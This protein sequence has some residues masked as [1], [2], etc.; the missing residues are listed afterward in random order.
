[1]MI[2]RSRFLFL[3]ACL[4]LAPLQSGHATGLTAPVPLTRDVLYDF[5]DQPLGPI[6]LG[7]AE[8]GQPESIWSA[9]I[10][11][12]VHT[13]PGN[14]ALELTLP[15]P[16]AGLVRFRAPQAG[17]L[18]EGMVRVRFQVTP[19]SLDRYMILFCNPTSAC[20]QS[21]QWIVPGTILL[22][23][24]GR[25]TVRGGGL[26]IPQQ[27]NLADYEAGETLNFV[28]DFNLD[29]NVWSL[30]LN[31][32]IILT[33]RPFTQ[34]SLGAIHRIA[35]GHYNDG[36][37]ALSAGDPMLLDDLEI[38]V[39][40]PMMTVLAAD[41]NDKTADEPIGTGGARE[42][43]P[44]EL[45][46]N[47][48]TK[49]VSL[50]AGNQALQLRK[51]G[52][53]FTHT[54]ILW[55]FLD[56][57]GMSE[58]TMLAEFKFTPQLVMAQHFRLEASNDGM[59]E[60]LAWINVDAVGDI[61]LAF[62]GTTTRFYPLGSVS[63]GETKA[64]R[65]ACNLDE[66]HCS[67]A[68]NDVWVALGKSFG[69][70]TSTD[71]VIDRFVSGFDTFT[72]FGAQYEFNDLR[73]LAEY[74]PGIPVAMEFLAQ[75]EDRQCGMGQPL[76]LAITAADGG[77]AANGIEVR[78]I[79]DHPDITPGYMAGTWTETW[80]GI[81]EFPWVIA[82]RRGTDLR[83][84]AEID[85]DFYPLSV[86]SDPFDVLPGLPT[87]TNFEEA[88]GDGFAGQLFDPPVA[89]QVLDTC[90]ETS[91][92]GRE[93][94]LVILEG[95]DGATLTGNTGVTDAEGRIAFPDLVIEQPGSYRLAGSFDGSM[96]SG[97]TP[98]FTVS[99]AP[100]AAATFQVQPSTVVAT[101]SISPAVEIYVEDVVDHPVPDGTPVTLSLVDPGSAVL[102]GG[103]ASTVEGVAV[104]D[105]LQVS[106]PGSFQLRASVP[107]LPSDAEPVSDLFAVI[108]GPAANLVF[109]QQPSS[110]TAG[111]TI[112][113]SV[114]VRVTDANGFDLDDGEMVSLSLASAPAGAAL[115]GTL[116][117]P[118]AGGIATFNDLSLTVAGD[119]SLQAEVAVGPTATSLPFSIAPAA[120]HDLV[121]TAEPSDAPVNQPLTPVVSVNATDTFGNAVSDGLLISL[122]IAEG[123][124]SASLTGA[125][126][127][128]T[129]G[130]AEFPS[131][132]IDQP[133]TYQLQAQAEG[134]PVDG[135]PISLAF[136]ILAGAPAS[137]S[138]SQ[139]PTT[140]SAGSAISPAV[141][142]SVTD[143][144]GFAVADG[145]PVNLSLASGPAEAALVGVTEQSTV[146]GIATFPDLT[147]EMTGSYTLEAAIGAE[148]QVISS[149]FQVNSAA[150]HVLTFLTPPSDGTVNQPL[151]P[152]VMVE[153]RDEFDNLVTESTTVDLMLIEYPLHG[154]VSGNVADTINGVATFENLRFDRPG[155]WQ[156]RARA[157]GVSFANRPTS[158]LFE[159]F[160]GPPANLAFEQQPSTTAMGEIIAPAVSVR[161]TD[162]DG[163]D[164]A[165]GS[166]VELALASGPSGADLSGTLSQAT[167]DGL[168]VF[169]DLSLDLAGTYTLQASVSGTGL[170]MTSSS[171]NVLDTTPGSAA[172]LTEPST[173]TA[174]ES[175]TPPVSV[176]VLD[177]EGDAIADGTAVVLALVDPG[178]AT[179]TGAVATT[180]NGIATFDN[181]VISHPGSYQLRAEISGLDPAAHPLSAAFDILP[182]P[183]A[184]LV[185]EQQPNST[186]AGTAIS[187]TVAVSVTDASGFAVADGTPVNL[188][189]ASGPAEAALVGVT[190]RNTVDGV[191]T[192][193]DLT[194]EVTGSYTLEAAIG[195]ELQVISSAFQ[196]NS[197][198]PHVLTFLTPPSDGT[199]NQALTP[200]ITV[201]A[202]DE[203][204][205][206]VTGATAITL[207]PFESPADGAVSGNVADTVD[208]MATFDALSF[209]TPGSWRLRADADGVPAEHRPISEPFDILSGA[210]D[211]LAFEQQ[212]ST[213]VVD[214]VIAPAVS[215]RVTDADGFDVADGTEVEL[216]LASGRVGANLTGTLTRATSDGLAVFD[217]LSLDQA[218]AYTLQASIS[219]TELTATS[220]SFDVIDTGP[221]SASFFSEPSDT[222]AGQAMSP[223]VAVEVLDGEGGPVA[224]GSAVVLV[225][226]APGEAT[227]SGG[228]ATTSDGIAEFDSLVVNRPGSYQLRAEISGLDPAEQ[229][230][231]ATFEVVPGPAA[232]IV[233]EQQPTDT[234]AGQVITP[235]IQVRLVDEFGNTLPDGQAIT[236]SIASGPGAG[237]ISGTLNQTTTDGVAMFDDLAIN[238]AGS[239][240]SLQFSHGEIETVSE[241]FA[242]TS[243]R[244]FSDRF[245]AD[246]KP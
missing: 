61:W 122:V 159:I 135:Q 56:E 116:T 151:S 87:F 117:R 207:S 120:A 9:S 168:A 100:P 3:V 215:V 228:V 57:I 101:E 133:G 40:K 41:F 155:T 190:E 180:S 186:T 131:L 179:L 183:A 209:N 143:A 211:M 169:G 201:E 123:P 212:P 6:G 65:I 52:T 158:E 136:D 35:V 72:S 4:L 36:A 230:V 62:P 91:I 203:F 200:A 42:G 191:A 51:T 225:L 187:P 164:V 28:A 13:G 74:P 199:V 236:V 113:P 63:F 237:T 66:R 88:P 126:A 197:A 222:A 227:L 54:E 157:P 85:D 21:N 182:G 114:T 49:I 107:D 38:S 139:Q 233:V 134:V 77:P 196:V 173:T 14:R 205:N 33:D 47:L 23:P 81:A 170:T 79:P 162:A 97:A 238:Q 129:S 176:E 83:L 58:G 245:Q 109:E 226:V 213:T 89:V 106:Q 243:D 235:A 96:L 55:T 165:D 11:E 202:R 102:S 144:D 220:A 37:S 167:S 223:A 78:L 145:T 8:A 208:G 19:S 214:E 137:I 174:G 219:G 50:G 210:A 189:L 92:A 240:Y 70:T 153:A 84:I 125:T 90:G 146:D 239:E 206:L 22:G 216:A 119:Y 112:S 156:I 80:A 234:L 221:A 141:A 32:E 128:T 171:F 111:S 138:F 104:F 124:T 76:E 7:G 130:L 26:G 192:F 67:V 15:E 231:S 244:L 108:P 64:M 45:D 95:P 184:N 94:S 242:I 204:N 46:S 71:I 150:P 178:D 75:P 73:V 142:V 82:L 59:R 163:F 69:D 34:D 121:F 110:T 198:A 93:I 152:A 99:A 118:T 229:P 232:S 48:T 181:L 30:A 194:I 103:T 149:A 241:Y 177:G 127:S 29:A 175:M 140:I 39:E 105:A 60:T 44:V 98:L 86:I 224:D 27:I 185:F 16:G 31:G 18:Q 24:T 217:D 218:G 166:V 1:M 10:A 17:D 161:V 53:N 5:N 195:A 188:S 147:I 25:V 172:F 193:P 132:A 2:F 148:L 43:E 115:S 160:A 154:D 12:V 246:V 20:V 68:V